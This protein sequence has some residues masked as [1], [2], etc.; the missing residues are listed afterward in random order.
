LLGMNNKQLS[1]S[2]EDYLEVILH[3]QKEKGRVR[4]REIAEKM[5][6]SLPSVTGALKILGGEGLVEY[7]PYDLV[8]LSE[9]GFK[10]AENIQQKHE[11]L[12]DFFVNV[13][14]ADKDEAAKA[15]CAMEHALSPLL[16]KKMM[17]FLKNFHKGK[18]NDKQ[19]GKGNR[20]TN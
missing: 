2:R 10:T 19:T 7:S 9:R 16:L 15:A 4:V 3:I 8:R 18:I 17:I 1:S 14:N 13:L 20:S 11:I 6:V 5:N 12:M